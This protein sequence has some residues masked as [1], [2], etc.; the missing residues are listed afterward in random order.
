MLNTRKILYWAVT[1]VCC[2]L[3]PFGCVKEDAASLGERHDV[4]VRLNVGTR[5]V[6]ETDGTP[7]GAES[8]IH[9]LRVYAFVGGR[10][11]GHY[12]TNN[13]TD[14]P[15]TFFMD[16]T[17]YSTT[18]QQMDFYVVANEGAMRT[19]G[20]EAPA[21]LSETTSENQLNDFWFTEL[22]DITTY[23]LPMF[24]KLSAT[25]DFTKVSDKTP[26]DP[27]H[28]GHTLIESD[29]KFELQR[30]MGKLGVFAAK[31]RG[32]TGELRIT[33]LTMLSS[34]TLTR[35]Y[36]MPQ[37]DETLKNIT[38]ISGD[39]PLKVIEDAVTA[40]LANNITDEQ[41]KDPKNYTPV[42]NAPYYPFENPWGSNTWNVPGDEKGNVLQIEYEYDG[43]ARTG[44]VYLPP[45]ERNHYYTV[46][47]LMHNDGKITVEYT[48]ADWEGETYPIEFNYPSYDNPIA[49][50][51]GSSL[52]EGGKYPQPEVYYNPD[53]TSALGSYSFSFKMTAPTG[54]KWTPTL[55][56][57]PGKFEVSVYQNETEIT[58][59]DMWVASPE[60]YEI[61]VRAL[62][63]ENVGE[64][65][66]LGISYRPSWLGDDETSMLLING[67]TG[68]LKWEGSTL[69]ETIVIRQVE[70]PQT[71]N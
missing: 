64:T 33:G 42:L 62:S 30:P 69:A 57:N 16:L 67:L 53:K 50:W 48:V 60:A 46:C 27:N 12:F 66:S 49:P 18:T 14:L 21:S 43:A 54:Q 25:L 58:D 19:Q 71:Q 36:L 45:I 47:C 11:A 38:S 39:F 17:F 68:N 61:R 52:P 56:D 32:E 6:S 65:V 4:A 3:L 9:T 13:V 2:G 22:R 20:S 44:L 5:A 1:A 63:A 8:A 70:V 10:P 35:N 15:H 51:V 59:A 37:S 24:C 40:E 55:L 41:R 29:I 34:G 28:A 31:P 23:G 7:A 26:T